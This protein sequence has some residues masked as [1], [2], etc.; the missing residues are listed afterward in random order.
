MSSPPTRP[1]DLTGQLPQGTV[2]LEAS[3][4][5]GKT[6]TITALALRYLAEGVATFEQLLLV[7][8]SRNATSE[9]GSRLYQRLLDCRA[10]LQ[11]YL[12]EGRRPHDPVD[13]LLAAG[14]DAEVQLRL[15]RVEQALGDFDRATIATTHQFCQRM[16]GELG[17]LVDH[18]ETAQFVADLG[19]LTE[20]VARDL[21]LRD[22]AN[23][24]EPPSLGT[25]MHDAAKA[26]ATD[27]IP[28]IEASGDAETSERTRFA[29][30]VR[31]VY[32]ERKRRQGNYG[33]DDMIARLRQALL[34]A[35]T[36]TAAQVLLSARF[37]VV[38]VDEF[39]DT[40]DSQWDILRSAFHHRST[41]ILIGDPKQAIYLFRGADVITYLSAAQTADAVH[42]LASNHRSDQAVTD[43][44]TDLFGRANLGLARW[45][46][47][48]RTV[49][50]HHHL[51]RIDHGARAL[52]AVSVR[53]LNLE[54]PASGPWETRVPVYNDVVAYVLGLLGHDA[55]RILDPDGVKRSRPLRPSD[56]AI[57]IE[58]NWHG[59]DLK[60]RLLAAGISAVCSGEPSIHNSQAARDWSALLAALGRPNRDSVIRAARTS[61][62]GW[63]LPELAMAHD[64]EMATL[65]LRIRALATLLHDKGVLAVHELLMARHQLAPR[66]LSMPDGERLLTDL[67][68]CAQLLENARRSRSL[69]AADLVDWL[70]DQADHVEAEDARARSRRLETDRSAVQV[71]T[72]HAAK[73]MEFPVVL[74]PDASHSLVRE[75]KGEAMQLHQ[76]EQLVLDL[77]PSHVRVARR[78]AHDAEQQAEAMRR[79]Y[80]AATRAQSHLVAWWA[81]NAKSTSDSPLHRL[82]AQATVLRRTSGDEVVTLDPGFPVRGALGHFLADSPVPIVAFEAA[83]APKRPSEDTSALLLDSRVFT[84][85][86]D[87][88]WIRTSY[89]RLTRAVHQD[90]PSGQGVLES[91]EPDLDEALPTMATDRTPVPSPMAQLPGGVQFGSVVHAILEQ[92]DPCSTDLLGELTRLG[93]ETLNRLPIPDLAPAA[94]GTALFTVMKTPLGRL[95]DERCLSDISRDDRLAELDFELPLGPLTKG[96]AGRS[97]VADLAALFA[98][99]ELVARGDPLKSYGAQL[100]QS[101][102]AGQTLAGFLTGSIDAVLR[103]GSTAQPRFVVVDYKTN[104]IPVVPGDELTSSHY[105][106]AA[107]AR[108]MIEAHYPLQALLYCVALHR[109]LDH[110]LRGYRP[111]QHL[112]G[113]GYLFVRG[114]AGTATPVAKGLPNGVFTWCPSAALVQ[115]ASRV[116]AGGEGHGDPA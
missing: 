53:A 10:A 72:V 69:S 59:R 108:A 32:E 30:Q 37:P 113:V 57:I 66:L 40:D 89:S 115:A 62:I 12:D 27:P 34:D 111:E 17:M 94:L 38:L 45:P 110:R 15:A 78:Q 55:T 36:G 21:Y 73:G 18:D 33:Y 106:Q 14:T 47:P 95:G 83:E 56:I 43:G 1:F 41:L 48:V 90:A 42:T 6:F 99:D 19:G 67:A 52:P 24:Q 61:L 31:R 76:G 58:S 101:P 46:I 114:M 79:L 88:E 81:P 112:G 84:R 116:L 44:I 70:A 87:T 80:V 60:T 50:S 25:L 3:A 86:I 22:Y 85:S 23:A 109:H 93:A 100:A 7:T 104:R 77:S 68:D 74:L 105:T 98:R 82:L 8:F 4:G 28:I 13:A 92:V 65:Y 75:D 20:E 5:T 107:M 16:L 71:L 29:R 49:E 26:V 11:T 54:T 2:V 64:D 51:S 9:L 39:Q 63:S 103:V 96:T 102:S 97:H 91:D 35:R